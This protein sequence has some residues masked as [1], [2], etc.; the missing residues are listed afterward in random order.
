MPSGTQS[1]FLTLNPF[2][3]EWTLLPHLLGQVRFYQKGCLGIFYYYN[4]FFE[5][6]LLDET[7]VDL[8]QMSLSAAS[9]LGLYCLQMSLLWDARLKW[10]KGTTYSR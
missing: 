2:F 8:D 4:M 7:R 10:V 3:A 6:P 1:V 5:I 9:D